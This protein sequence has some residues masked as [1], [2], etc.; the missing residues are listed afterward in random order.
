MRTHSRTRCFETAADER[1]MQV[2]P[3]T[4]LKISGPDTRAHMCEL[5]QCVSRSGYDRMCVS[6]NG[7]VTTSGR[8][9]TWLGGGGSAYGAGVVP[10]MQ[11]R[12]CRPVALDHFELRLTHAEL[13]LQGAAL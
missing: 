5:L 4:A 2:E 11:A 1:H 8:G 7:S 6:G 13:R 12:D 9:R 3:K 10:S